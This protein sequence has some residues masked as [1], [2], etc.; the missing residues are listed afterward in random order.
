MKY[1]KKESEITNG[2]KNSLEFG[3]KKYLQKLQPIFCIRFL[4]PLASFTEFKK[5]II[6]HLFA[7]GWH[8]NYTHI[9]V[10]KYV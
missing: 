3:N 6:I 7:M 8:Q 1:F 10:Y 5:Y 4:F 9:C 2:T